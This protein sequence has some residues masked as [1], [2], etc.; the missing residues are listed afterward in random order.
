[1]L[2]IVMYLLWFLFNGRVTIELAIIGLLICG[3]LYYFT[4]KFIREERKQSILK[5]HL[6]DFIKYSM[7]LFIEII[8]AN[9]AVMILILNPNMSQWHPSFI[10]F[11]SQL[12]DERMRVLLANSITLTPGTITVGMEEKEFTVH[13]LDSREE[14]QVENGIFAQKLFEIERRE[15]GDR[16]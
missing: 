10:T 8:I 9:I 11:T 2:F 14:E 4:Q 5:G 12:E 1:M 16:K 6:F 3:A 15:K 13:V 7:V